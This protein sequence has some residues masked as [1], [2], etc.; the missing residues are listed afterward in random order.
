ME[1]YFIHKIKLFCV[2]MILNHV[3]YIQHYLYYNK[4]I[5][6]LLNVIKGIASLY[7]PNGKILLQILLC[8]KRSLHSVYILV[9]YDLMAFFQCCQF[10]QFPSIHTTHHHP[11]IYRIDFRQEVNTQRFQSNAL[12]TLWCI[13][14][15]KR[16]SFHMHYIDYFVETAFTIGICLLFIFT[17]N[18]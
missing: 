7:L 6:L 4:I 11:S 18:Y 5:H 12:S 13:N 9:A 2:G 3:V 17:D 1:W 16:A 8:I 10:T 14:T 15:V